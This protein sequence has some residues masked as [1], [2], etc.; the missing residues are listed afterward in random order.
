MPER[1]APFVRRFRG[2]VLHVFA[3]VAFAVA[4]LM[5]W[6]ANATGSVIAGGVAFALEVIAWLALGRGGSKGDA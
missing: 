2:L 5:L 3:L 6:S 1:A 4:V